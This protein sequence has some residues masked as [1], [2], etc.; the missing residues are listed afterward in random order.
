[1][2]VLDG[3]VFRRFLFPILF[4]CSFLWFLAAYRLVGIPL[5]VTVI[6]LYFRK[7]QRCATRWVVLVWLAL[8]GTT[9]LPV[10]ISFRNYPGP[11]RFVPLV[12][13]L[14]AR[15]TVTRAERGEC[16]LGGCVVTGYEPKWVWVW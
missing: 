2:R 5:L 1:M 13:G 8:L 3:P 10:D 14:P 11:P 15:E 12:M 7:P 6:V 9:L 4:A 16:M